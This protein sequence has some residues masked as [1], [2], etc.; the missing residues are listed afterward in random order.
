[1]QATAMKTEASLLTDT[2]MFT[3]TRFLIKH[4]YEYLS[5]RDDDD[6]DDDADDE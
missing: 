3:V 4:T 6:D 5:L 1:M 2:I